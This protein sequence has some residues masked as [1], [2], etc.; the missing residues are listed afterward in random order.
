MKITMGPLPIKT[1]TKTKTGKAPTFGIRDARSITE[2]RASSLLTWQHAL[3]TYGAEPITPDADTL[4]AFHYAYG[5]AHD[6][7]TQCVTAHPSMQ[8]R[9]AREEGQVLALAD[10]IAD[11]IQHHAVR[12]VSASEQWATACRM[13][14]PD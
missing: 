10:W 13:A 2:Q 12:A 8:H 9:D 1:Q 6:A 11:T 7:V 14:W 4:E 3:A 5:A